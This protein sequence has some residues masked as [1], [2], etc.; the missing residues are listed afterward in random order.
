MSC[1]LAVSSRMLLNSMGKITTVK[2]YFLFVILLTLCFQIN[3]CFW[4]MKKSN[5]KNSIFNREYVLSVIAE[6]LHE[7]EWNDAAK[8]SY[9]IYLKS[10]ND[11]YFLKDYETAMILF[12]DTMDQNPND[13]RV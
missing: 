12:F 2:Q 3:S 5:S 10:L 4:M 9:S 13:A 11:Y 8:R 1:T 7:F 6:S